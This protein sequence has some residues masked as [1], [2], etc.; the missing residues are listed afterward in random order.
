ML[1]QRRIGFLLNFGDLVQPLHTY[2]APAL[3]SWLNASFFEAGSF[4][5]EPGCGRRLY[6]KCETTIDVCLHDNP[7]RNIRI[8]LLGSVVELLAKSHHINAQWTKC[9]T[10]FRRRLRIAGKAVDAYRGLEGWTSVHFKVY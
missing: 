1:D 8:I 7:H 3:V 4:L 5:D 6:D 9:L 10:D 2:A